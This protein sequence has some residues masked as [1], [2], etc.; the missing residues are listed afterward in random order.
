VT[1]LGFSG[2]QI[3]C[4]LL[5]QRQVRIGTAEGAGMEVAVIDIAAPENKA[6]GI[7]AARNTAA[8]NLLQDGT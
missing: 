3:Q 8:A 2:Y 7:A 5:Q 1:L 6:P 4:H